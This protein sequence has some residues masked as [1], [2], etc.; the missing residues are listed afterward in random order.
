MKK[1]KAENKAK[2]LVPIS[3]EA[4]V[5]FQPTASN[6]IDNGDASILEIDPNEGRRKRRKTTSPA[7]RTSRD[8]EVEGEQ[9]REEESMPKERPRRSGR[10]SA[11]IFYGFVPPSEDTLVGDNNDSDEAKTTPTKRGRPRK[12]A[13]VEVIEDAAGPDTVLD[14]SESALNVAPNPP[15]SKPVET[16]ISDKPKKILKFNPKTGT[17]GSPPAKKLVVASQKKGKKTKSRLVTVHYGPDFPLPASTGE[18]ID[19]I[20]A[21]SVSIPLHTKKPPI[22]PKPVNVA[23]QPPPKN[24]HPLFMGKSVV[25]STESAPPKPTAKKPCIIDLTGPSFPRLKSPIRSTGTSSAAFAGFGAPPKTLKFPGAVEPAW[26]WQGMVHVRG[27]DQGIQ[28]GFPVMESPIESRSRKSK[29]TATQIPHDEHLLFS[30]AADLNV[31]NVL[32]TVAEI[33]LNDYPPLPSSLRVPTKHLESGKRI[34]QRIRSQVLARVGYNQDPDS[35]EDEL[36]ATQPARTIHPALTKRYNTISLSLSAFDNSQFETQSWINKYSPQSAAEVLQTGPEALVLK[37]WLQTLTVN[38]VDSG[39]AKPQGKS[40]ASEPTGKRKRKSKKDD[41]IVGSDEESDLDELTEPDE[42]DPLQGNPSGRKTVVRTGNKGKEVGKLK[43]SVLIS[44]PH[45][46]G[47]TSAVYAVA[48]ELGFEV[49]EINS[50]SRRSGK[51]IMEKVGDMTRNHQVQRKNVL[52]MPQ[53][54]EDVERIEQALADDIQS[55]RQGTMNSFFQPKAAPKPKPKVQQP[56]PSTKEETPK[57]VPLNKAPAKE[58]KQSLIL[59]EEVDVLYEEDKNF[60]TT[61]MDLFVNS[62]RP[63]IM[64]CTDESLV[65]DLKN[66]LHAIIRFNPP[67]VDLATDYMLLVAACEGHVLRREA[68]KTLY[69][70]RKFDLRASISELNFWCQF[71]VGDQK[72]GGDWYY[73]RYA[74]K[75]LDSQG[76]KIRVVSEDT[77]H[78]GM[79]CLSRDVLTDEVDVLNVE[80][81]MLHELWDG[82]GLDAGDWQK[83]SPI[84]DWSTS[85]QFTSKLAALEV[86]DDFAEYMSVSDLCSASIFAPTHMEELDTTIPILSDKT[87]EKASQDYILGRQLIQASPVHHFQTLSK[88]MSMYL[89]SQA[90]HLLHTHHNFPPRNEQKILSLLTNPSI[91]KTFS[92][93][94]LSLAF[95]PISYSSSSTLSSSLEPSIFDRTTTII[96]LDVAPYVRG[97]VAYD[98]KLGKERLEKSNLL[99]E[100]G[101]MKGG[102]KRM[103]TTRAAIS[104]LEG[105]VR[106][107]VRRERYFGNLLN[108]GWVGRTGGEGWREAVEE[109]EERRCDILLRQEME[110]KTVEMV[111]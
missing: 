75:D 87:L 8:D 31:K 24:L 19:Q 70:T 46:S 108:S 63:I 34:Q 18:K 85:F 92:R 109:E 17:I 58:Q 81:E 83:H 102:R 94:D 45:G 28:N 11:A 74:G 6:N 21:G 88:D 40:E 111:E 106:E 104:A 38:A 77:Y 65:P 4:E 64:T 68:V 22:P 49:F 56:A 95:D 101:S 99:S 103:R 27:L 30:V 35:S 15:A 33:N 89:K 16:L 51:D 82:W 13:Q 67:P 10:D 50:S 20:L 90:R 84:E 47:K 100:G 14:F 37:E 80:E 96:T 93:R 105:G 71:G 98:Q 52:S 42:D 41:F 60:W 107:K 66:A 7:S 86:Y 54:D 53:V 2:R 32:K 43:N 26:P 23:K 72:H 57:L 78:T 25:K 1:G 9:G 3:K 73:R 55:G 39:L 79:G 36:Q 91:S 61:V 48:K 44:G 76:N 110:V 69:E 59:I 29:Y 97:I 62:K 12:K 5:N